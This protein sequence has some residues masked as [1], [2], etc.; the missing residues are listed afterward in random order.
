MENQKNDKNSF[1]TSSKETIIPFKV[2]N[3]KSMEKTSLQ[4]PASDLIR[5]LVKNNYAITCLQSAYLV[6]NRPI[7]LLPSTVWYSSV[8][9]NYHTAIL[10]D[11]L[12]PIQNQNHSHSVFEH[13]NS[14][15]RHH[16][17]IS[18]LSTILACKIGPIM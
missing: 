3:Y 17:G 16:L 10:K 11:S 8:T 4:I 9:K 6:N 1:D 5:D 15:L 13:N 2:I 18:V 14:L 12:Q 7:W